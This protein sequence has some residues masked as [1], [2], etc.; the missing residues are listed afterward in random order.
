MN[1]LFF[2]LIFLFA[3][4]EAAQPTIIN[5]ED[6][7]LDPEKD[8]LIPKYIEVIKPDFK[9]KISKNTL[10][11]LNNNP[12]NLRSFRTGKFRKFNT[13]EEGYAALLYDLN[14][15][16]SSR[17]I[18]T[19]ST[20]TI[21]EFINIYAPKCENDVDNYIKVFCYET[22]LRENDLLKLQRAEHLARGIIRMEDSNLYKNLYLSQTSL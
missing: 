5:M 13:L 1:R 6:F 17:S 2:I 7:S 15:K 3:W 14:L 8:H 21:N 10:A 18:W 12:G 19:D 16:I 11:A 4:N 9:Q 20:T 22:G